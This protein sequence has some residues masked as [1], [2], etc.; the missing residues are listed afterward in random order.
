MRVMPIMIGQADKAATYS[1]AEQMF[2][3]HV[4]YTLQPW[5][6]RIE[7]SVDKFLLTAEDRKRGIY[8]KFL[9]NALM[10]GAAKDRAEYY[11]RMWQMGAMNPNEIRAYEEQ[12]PYEGGNTYRV[13]LN[14]GDSNATTD[15]A[16]KE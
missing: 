9:P 4:K 14:M 6:R 13:P 1:S 10:R 11:F 3:A 15:A 8:A 12:N 2:L 7:K 5:F 16:V